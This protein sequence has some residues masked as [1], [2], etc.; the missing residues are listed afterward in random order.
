MPS[1]LLFPIIPFLATLVVFIY[2]IVVFAYLYSCGELTEVWEAQGGNTTMPVMPVRTRLC[3]IASPTHTAPCA[4]S[5]NIAR[6]YF[7]GGGREAPQYEAP[8]SPLPADDAVRRVARLL[9]RVPVEQR[10]AVHDAVPHLRA[11]LDQ[12]VHPGLRVH[13]CGGRHRQ[14]LLGARRFEEHARLPGA[15]GLEAHVPLPPRHHR[16]G[17][18]H[19]RDHTV[20]AA[21]A[22]V[23]RPQDQGA[24][25]GQRA[26]QVRHVLRQVLHVVPREGHQVHQQECVHPCRLQRHL[27]LRERPARGDA[28]HRQRGAARGGQ[29][30]GRHPHLAGQAR[31]RAHVRRHRRV[32]HGPASVHEPAGVPRDVPLL[33][34]PR[35]RHLGYP[36]VLRGQHL[37]PRVRDGGGYGPALLLRGLREE[38]R[39]SQVRAAALAIRHRQVAGLQ[40]EQGRGGEVG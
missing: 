4:K 9:L 5:Q 3:P 34:V 28:D 6:G 10:A 21:G 17:L 22:R 26:A 40:P 1:I 31:H 12:P 2:W 11:P 8:S 25:G 20:R 7:H 13:C 24:A 35:H 16:P 32:P 37:L 19:R 23:P 30:G 15:G 38:R 18:V 36:G 27:L 14:F 39:G 29:H 33:A